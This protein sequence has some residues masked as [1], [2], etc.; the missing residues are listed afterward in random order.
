[1]LQYFA[2]L[3]PAEQETNMHSEIKI[4]LRYFYSEQTLVSIP[5]IFVQPTCEIA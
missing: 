2:S 1:M 3:L 4:L 5:S